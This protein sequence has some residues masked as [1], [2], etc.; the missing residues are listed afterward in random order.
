MEERFLK[1]GMTSN[2]QKVIL[3]KVK[4]I[5]KTLA[6]LIQEKRKDKNSKNDNGDV[7][8]NMEIF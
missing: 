8:T 2:N 4:E 6:R 5:V 7:T 1:T 3:W